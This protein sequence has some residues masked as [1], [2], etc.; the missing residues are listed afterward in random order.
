MALQISK[1]KQARPIRATVYGV[2]GVGKSTL[3]SQLPKPLFLDTEDGSAQLEVDRVTIKDRRHLEETMKELAKDSL[4]YK[5]VVI[6]TADWAEQMLA[7]HLLRT[8]GEESIEDFGFGKGY[9]KLAEQFAKILALADALIDSG[10]HVV[11]LAHAK[12]QKVSPPDQINGYDRYELKLSKGSAPKLVEWSELVL[13]INFEV[14]L[15]NGKDGKAKGLGGDTRTIYTTR[16][17]AWDAK[18]RFG[19]EEQLPIDSPEVLA[20]FNGAAPKPPGNAQKAT[21]AKAEA[22]APKEEPKLETK[23]PTKTQASDFEDDPLK[24]LFIEHAEKVNAYLVEIN[25]VAQGQTWENLTEEQTEKIRT[26]MKRFF[27]NIGVTLK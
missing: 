23:E 19:L 21:P 22:P 16:T 20:L 27:Q 17:A 8:T 4:G 18:N 12:V 14:T 11:F 2:P 26:R 24:A 25:Y 7:D 9:T 10:L 3:G 5:T 1:G 15:V 13:F 6:D